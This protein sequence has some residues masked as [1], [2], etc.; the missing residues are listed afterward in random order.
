MMAQCPECG[1]RHRSV[2]K[3]LQCLRVMLR[4]DIRDSRLT[5]K[6]E[7]AAAVLHP[8]KWQEAAEIASKLEQFGFTPNLD[9]T[10]D[11]LSRL[12][13][14]GYAE[15]RRNPLNARRTQYRRAE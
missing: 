1:A 9:A 13:L 6:G 5:T 3:R 15:S 4:R 2:R 10:R 12:V 14:K 11:V 7:A 8:T